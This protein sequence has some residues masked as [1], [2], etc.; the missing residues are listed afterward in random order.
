VAPPVAISIEYQPGNGSGVGSA[1]YGSYTATTVKDDNPLF[2]ALKS[3]AAQL[4]KSGYEGIRGIVICDRG[5]RMFTEMSNWATFSMDEVVKDFLR[6]NSSVAF[7]VTIGIRALHLGRGPFHDDFD[8]RLFIRSEDAAEDWASV[9]AGLLVQVTRSLPRMHQTPENAVNSLKWNRSLTQHK[10]YLGGWEMKGN[11][12]RI[13]TRELLDL[14]TGKLD[15][16]RFAQHH[17]LG[18]GDMFSTFQARGKMLKRAEVVRRP[19][20]DDDWIIL[21]FSED[22]PAVSEF[23]LPKADKSAEAEPGD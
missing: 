22:D 6:Q 3:K 16:K 11:E 23:R 17:A 8:P 5:S 4:K 10:L 7:V 20:E 18:N 15:Q 19:D 12:I 13:S 14:L 2:N 21:E 1:S 9:L